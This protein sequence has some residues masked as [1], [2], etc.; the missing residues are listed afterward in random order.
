MFWVLH[1]FILFTGVTVFAQSNPASTEAQAGCGPYCQQS[2]SANSELVLQQAFMAELQRA[3]NSG[4]PPE[5]MGF[6]NPQNQSIPEGVRRASRA[7][8]GIAVP[9]GDR[10]RARDLFNNTPLAEVIRRIQPPLK[11]MIWD[12]LKKPFMLIRL[13]SACSREIQNVCF[14]KEFLMA[15]VL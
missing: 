5:G 15:P 3:L 6:I 2:S 7:T 13:I 11:A 9:A 10:V 4:R 8:F 12:P 14:S 1:L